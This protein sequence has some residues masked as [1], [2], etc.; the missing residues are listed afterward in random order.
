[1][2][3]VF[4]PPTETI[5]IQLLQKHQNVDPVNRPLKS[6]N[7]Y[8][9]KSAKADTAILGNKTFLR[10]FKKIKITTINE[11]TDLLEY[12]TPDFKV[13]CL[14]LIMMLKAFNISHTQYLKGHSGSEKK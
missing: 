14:S 11:S 2:E 1:M 7:K 4:L 9:T 10:Y 5:T 12:Q 6:W 8:Q 13:P 3:S